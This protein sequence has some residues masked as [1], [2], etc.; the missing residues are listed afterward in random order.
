MKKIFL[1]RFLITT[2]FAATF[3]C[4]TPYDYQASSGYEDVIV[5]E[6]TIT[7][8]NKTQ[9][10]KLTRAYKLDDK[11]PIFEKGATVY[12]TDNTGNKYDFK[13]NTENYTSVAPFQVVAGKQYQLHVR[14]KDG[15]NYASSNETLPQ[16]TEIESIEAT[17]KTKDNQLGVEIT[18]NTFDPTNNSHY[19]RYEYEE[20]YRIVAPKYYPKKAIPVYF[21][22]GSYPPG[23]VVLEDRTED[24]RVCYSNQNS[25]ELLLTSTNDLSEDRVSNFPVR[26]LASTDYIIASRYSILVK[27]Y[28]QSLAAHTFFQTLKEISN[29]G[30]I[31]SQTQPGFFYGNMKSVENPNEKVIGYFDV[32]SYSEKRLFFSFTDLLSGEPIP[33][34]PYTCPSPIPDDQVKQYIFNYCFNKNPDFEC[35]GELIMNLLSSGFKV[36]FPTESPNSYILYPV[37]CGDCTSFSSN[38]K[39]PFWID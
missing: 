32:S 37:E 2:L 6:S 26:F 27:Q 18:V 23:Q 8:Q 17:K 29:S 22:A 15:R 38:V 34:Y 1:I 33:K 4:T 21:P 39:P 13:E 35:Q 28:V 14:T 11:A 36:Y 25:N 16:Q 3:G 5:I 24:V 12:V 20:T 7:N 19:Y 10:V 30:S 31:L 9:Q